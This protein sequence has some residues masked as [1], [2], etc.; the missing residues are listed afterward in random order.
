MF[1]GVDMER[2]EQRQQAGRLLVVGGSQGSFFAVA[3]GASKALE[4]GVG[5]VK[6][7]LPD[8]LKAKIPASP[9]V[10]LVPSEASGGFGKGAARLAIAAAEN[11]DYV[12]VIG[13][14]GKNSETAAFAERLVVEC[15]KPVL[16]TRD[17][18][19][20]LAPSAG[21]WLERDGLVLCATLPQLQKIFKAVYYPK[22][23]TLSMPTN[24][25][26]ETLHKFST[27]YPMVVVTYHNGQVVVAS[28]GQVVTTDIADTSFTPISL[29]QGELAVKMAALAIWNPDR[30]FE[31]YVTAILM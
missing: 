29:W 14:V 20:L 2:P 24:Q 23:I 13:D 11:A 19:D 18:I 5:E 22:M 25:L 8:S 12:L 7:L 17:A 16:M 31:S 30:G 10:M 1:S 4:V 21:E 28:G 9:D 6:T 27:T 3:N 15:K 26:V